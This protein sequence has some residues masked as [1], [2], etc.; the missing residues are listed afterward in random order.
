MPWT[1]V[2][3]NIQSFLCLL[4]IHRS[5]HSCH[6]CHYVNCMSGHNV[7]WHINIPRILIQSRIECLFWIV[8]T[9]KNHVETFS[10]TTWVLMSRTKLV[11]SQQELCQC[12][13][14]FLKFVFFFIKLGCFFIIF[15]CFSLKLVC[16]STVFENHTCTNRWSFQS[17]WWRLAAS[18]EEDKMRKDANYAKKTC[19]SFKVKVGG[20]R[21]AHLSGYGCL[22]PTCGY[23]WEKKIILQSPVYTCAYCIISTSG[24][25]SLKVHLLTCGT[26]VG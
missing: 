6:L 11:E 10:R 21:L 5:S 20:Q 8:V 22:V 16:F 26:Q 7:C 13:G 24:T 2:T 14:L 1:I 25:R 9:H 3:S 19:Y 23:K 4:I 17:E 15:V 12:W 18:G